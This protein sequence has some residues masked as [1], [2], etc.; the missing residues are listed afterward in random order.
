QKID[1]NG[2]KLEPN[3]PLSYWTF[4][5]MI[6]LGMIGGLIGVVMLIAM[7]GGRNPKP[8]RWL[9]FFMIAL[10]LLP[11]FA[12][13][14]GWI[15][16]EMG[17]QPWIVAGVLPTTAAVSPN[18]SAGS[19]L[20]STIAYTVVYG[21]LAVVEVGLFWKALKEG[22]PELSTRDQPVTEGEDTPLSFA[23]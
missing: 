12:I 6:T 22:L 16:T 5:I 7:R 3:V 18:V 20:F 4:R 9:T 15:F 10:P 13:S 14:F 11:L 23:Y 21:I 1:A 19:V 17:R 8:H 2:I